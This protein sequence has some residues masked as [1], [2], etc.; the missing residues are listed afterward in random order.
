MF[1]GT[2][3]TVTCRTAAVNLAGWVEK[4]SIAPGLWAEATEAEA[5]NKVA[6]KY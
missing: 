1:E 4:A 3:R 5:T 6:A 2:A